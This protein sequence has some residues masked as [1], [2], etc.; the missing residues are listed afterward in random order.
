MNL[1]NFEATPGRSILKSAN[2]KSQKKASKVL[3][4]DS[5]YEAS[6]SYT[7]S[8][9]SKTSF[10]GVEVIDNIDSAIS[11]EDLDNKENSHS[12]KNLKHLVRQDAITSFNGVDEIDNAISSMDFN[13]KVNSQSRK[14]SS[15][16]SIAQDNVHTEGLHTGV[17]TRSLRKS[18]GLQKAIAP[19]DNGDANRPSR[20]GHTAKAENTPSQTPRQSPKKQ[21]EAIPKS[22]KRSSKK[23]TLQED[24]DVKT[25]KISSRRSKIH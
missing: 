18:I 5:N 6:D 24:N 22:Q 25:P 2:T 13:D 20:S 4:N 14:K 15:K 7:S 16:R 23:K 19:S 17:M 8:D 10:E 3:F 12:E 1:I 21:D 9:K 11:S